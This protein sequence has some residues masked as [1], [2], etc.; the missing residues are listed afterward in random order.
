MENLISNIVIH[1]KNIKNM[2]MVIKLLELFTILHITFP[3][4]LLIIF[5]IHVFHNFLWI[6]EKLSCVRTC[7][8][9][10]PRVWLVR[11]IAIALR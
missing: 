4:T 9:L 3:H 6:V 10:L 8:L 7:V 1:I 11:I 5:V 2:P